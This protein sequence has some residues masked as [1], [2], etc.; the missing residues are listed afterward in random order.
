M[1][2]IKVTEGKSV[3]ALPHPLHIRTVRVFVNRDYTYGVF[4]NE[5]TL[6]EMLTGEQVSEYLNST[7]SVDL[8]VSREVAQSILNNGESPYTKQVLF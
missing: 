1:I 4:I 3:G 8:D 5:R 6:L 2:R 7:D